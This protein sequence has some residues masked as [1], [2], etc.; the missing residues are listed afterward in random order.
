MLVLKYL[1]FLIVTFVMLIVFTY[2]YYFNTYSNN[3]IKAQDKIAKTSFSDFI[4]ESSDYILHN[5]T[6]LL[7]LNLNAL[8]KTNVFKNITIELT[9]HLIT[10]KNIILNAEDKIDFSWQLHDVLV[11]DSYGELNQIDPL[12]YVLNNENDFDYSNELIIKFQASSFNEITNTISK[13]KFNMPKYNKTTVINQ[14]YLSSLLRKVLPIKDNIIKKKIYAKLVLEYAIVSYVQDNNLIYDK[15]QEEITQFF[16]YLCFIFIILF[17]LFYIFNYIHVQGSINKSLRGLNEYTDDILNNR[18]YTYKNNNIHYE[19]IKNVST[20]ISLLSSKMAKLMSE[21][22]VNRNMIEVNIATDSLTNLPTNKIFVNDM[23]MIY[24]NKTNSYIIKIKL[25]CLHV[26][27]QRN[28]IENTDK[29]IK[30]FVT[31]TK[32]AMNINKDKEDLSFYRINGSDFIIVAKNFRFLQLNELMEDIVKE[33]DVIKNNFDI[34]SKI[35]HMVSIPFNQYSSTMDLDDEL[36]KLYSN[37]HNSNEQITYHIDKRKEHDSI[38]VELEKEVSDIIHNNT[39]DLSYKYNTY[40]YDN[41]IKTLLMQ[42]VVPNIINSNDEVMPIGTFIAVAQ[43]MELAI[44]FDKKL[45]TKVFE[46][47]KESEITHKYAINL[48]IHSILN[49]EFMIWLESKLLFDYHD[50]V[51]NTVFSITSFTAKNNFDEFLQFTNNVKRFNSQIILKRF[52]YDDFTKEQL[53]KIDISYIR[54]H[55]HETNNINS[56]KK[57]RLHKIA[58]YS[59]SKNM[60][61]LADDVQNEEDNNILKSLGFYGTS[62]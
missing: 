47:I 49:N 44:E 30:T 13:I 7:K 36:T 12:I 22:I 50:F 21:M 54:V 3:I 16:Y 41:E 57:I 1:L 9:E 46:H 35:I 34:E 38:N 59:L 8:S 43:E 14:T 56:D 62:K 6:E 60:L 24:L 28:T 2:L 61:L 33:N 31:S 15:I 19:D 53:N 42:E 52:S 26:F 17:I 18:F 40:T 58:D 27:S 5:Q 37:T 48:S 32:D 20:N 29:L 39:F 51:E 55:S 25:A 45:I 11:D 4:N 10:K 23:K